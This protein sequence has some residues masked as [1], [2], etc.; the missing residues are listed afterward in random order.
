MLMTRLSSAA[1]HIFQH[2]HEDV[3]LEPRPDC[4][5]RL[6]VNQ[7]RVRFLFLSNESGQ[8]FNFTEWLPSRTVSPFVSLP[9]LEAWFITTNFFSYPP[10]IACFPT[11]FLIM[12]T[13]Q[14]KAS[15][16]F[17]FCCIWRDFAV[18]NNNSENMTEYI[19]TQ[20]WKQIQHAALSCCCVACVDYRRPTIWACKKTLNHAK[21][22]DGHTQIS[23]R[24]VIWTSSNGQVATESL[25]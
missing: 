7:T 22:Q 6:F 4:K 1:C 25:A 17:F 5:Q 9:L 14:K 12:T 13:E 19:D 15:Q 3:S 24:N 16:M 8:Y 11:H 10:N 20:I 18:I 21:S 2:P 23:N